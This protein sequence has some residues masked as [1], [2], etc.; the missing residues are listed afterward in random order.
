RPRVVCLEWLD[1]PIVAGHW[2]PEMVALAGGIDVLGQPG[3]PSFTVDWER[4]AEVSPDVLV[5]MPCGYD[6]EG[7]LHLAAGL[8]VHPAVFETP[9]FPSGRIW[10]VDAS[11]YFSRPGPRIVRGV[12]ILAAI[13]HPECCT[14]DGHQLAAPVRLAHS[15]STR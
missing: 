11:S 5:L 8:L 9:A 6:L 3:Q 2:V 14:V 15:S 12:E 4:V 10:A 13:L 7:T 1:P